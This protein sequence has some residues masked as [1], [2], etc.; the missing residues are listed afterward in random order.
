MSSLTGTTFR[1]V[2]RDVKKKMA[3]ACVGGIR[4]YKSLE[5]EGEELIDVEIT[6]DLDKLFHKGG[7]L[8]HKI[9]FCG[10]NKATMAQG[11]VVAKVV[12]KEKK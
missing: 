1:G 11:A 7:A 10:S 5:K 4:Y 3:V 6:V 9:V 2:L 8:Y 12:K